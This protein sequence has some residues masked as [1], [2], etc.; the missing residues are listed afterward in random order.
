MEAWPLR[1]S[2]HIAIGKIL[3]TD[4]F[5]RYSENLT[6]IADQGREF[7]AKRLRE[8]VA[9]Y[10]S[11]IYFGTAYH[12]NS[13]PVERYHRVLNSL[14]R[15]HLIDANR[16]KEDW[17]CF[18][19]QALYTMRCAPDS[20][21]K[22]SPF[23]RV[24][25]KHPC[26]MLSTWL[27]RDPND[28]L[29]I[30]DG[31]IILDRDGTRY[32]DPYPTKPESIPETT[33]IREDDEHLVVKTGQDTRELSKI[34][35]GEETCFSQVNAIPDG[36]FQEYAQ[37]KRDQFAKKR[38]NENKRCFNKKKQPKF[39]WPIERELVDW[40]SPFDPNSKDSRKLS[41]KWIGP[42]ICLKR[43]S[44]PYTVQ[45]ARINVSTG[46]IER[47]GRR[48]IHV[49]DLRPTLQLAYNNR[50]RKKWIPPWLPSQ[51]LH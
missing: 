39:Y 17:P 25:G 16:P 2:S 1:Q 8:L 32:N 47:E 27:G 14:I 42:L 24:Y 7:I 45:C 40:D 46:E 6:F 9:K 30:V 43:Y 29:E 4:I 33:I 13:L 12:P 23:Y 18:L 28:H 34:T 21:S 51:P 22:L 44:H 3:E 10:G 35:L 11:R 36:S 50:H 48:D 15:C 37:A 5:T 19:P 49:G 41:N 26:T 31:N 20:S 38:H